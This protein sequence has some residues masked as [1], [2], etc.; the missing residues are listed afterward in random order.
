MIQSNQCE[1]TANRGDLQFAEQLYPG[2]VL[3]VIVNWQGPLCYYVVRLS[4]TF[5]TNIVCRGFDAN[6]PRTWQICMY[7]IQLRGMA[8][9]SCLPT[10]GFF[11]HRSQS[12]E[13]SSSR[14]S[15]VVSSKVTQPLSAS[16]PSSMRQK[17]IEYL[18]HMFV[19]EIR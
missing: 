17:S 14:I 13:N 1:L 6:I 18:A 3:L 15:Y 10:C 9:S 16:V 12:T 2:K 4:E 8:V 19:W 11:K 7:V 5:Q